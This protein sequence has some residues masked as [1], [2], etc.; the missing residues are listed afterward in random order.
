MF[1]YCRT[2]RT[3]L[4]ES[5]D[6]VSACWSGDLQLNADSRFQNGLEIGVQTFKRLPVRSAVKSASKTGLTT[7]TGTSKELLAEKVLKLSKK[8]YVSDVM[9]SFPLAKGIKN[10]LSC[11]TQQSVVTDEI[12]QAHTYLMDR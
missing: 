11:G 2:S 12:I 7:S 9:S 10:P 8:L 4:A 6:F 3:N 5:P 1:C